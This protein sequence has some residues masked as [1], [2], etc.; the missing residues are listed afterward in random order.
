MDIKTNHQISRTRSKGSEYSH[1]SFA[2]GHRDTA[3]SYI[4][5]G[6]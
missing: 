4:Y 1:R 5:T 6:G 2:S 3:F